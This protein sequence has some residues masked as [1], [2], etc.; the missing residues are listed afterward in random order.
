MLREIIQ[1]FISEWG[2]TVPSAFEEPLDLLALCLPFSEGDGWESCSNE[3]RVG[4]EAAS[5]IWPYLV[6]TASIQHLDKF[7]DSSGTH[8]QVESLGLATVGMG[9]PAQ[10]RPQ[11]NSVHYPHC[12]RSSWQVPRARGW[13]STCAWPPTAQAGA[14]GRG[15]NLGGK[16]HRSSPS[17]ITTSLEEVHK[18]LS[19]KQG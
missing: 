2:R 11:G 5:D 7:E 10:K 14:H 4:Y 1:K 9:W 12:P 13:G 16:I 18:P 3:P 17:P 6:P 19:I 8:S 15:K